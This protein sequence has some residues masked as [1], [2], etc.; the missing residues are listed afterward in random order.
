MAGVS[1][2]CD[3]LVVDG[4]VFRV[5]SL[6][7]LRELYRRGLEATASDEAARAKHRAIAETYAAFC[8]L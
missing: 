1:E 5:L 2:E 4:I 8:S 3:T 7:A 6:P